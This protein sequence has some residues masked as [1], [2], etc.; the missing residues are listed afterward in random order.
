MLLSRANCSARAA[1]R[2][3]TAAASPPTCRRPGRNTA[4]A[5]FAVPMMPQRTCPGEVIVLS[6][7]RGIEGQ[8][9]PAALVVRD[10]HRVDD[11]L[12]PQPV[13][14]VPLVALDLAED[15][16]GE[17][18]G[19]VGVVEGPPRLTRAAAGRVVAVRDRHVP[20]LNIIRPGHLQRLADAELLDQPGAGCALA[21]VDAHLDVP[22]AV[23][24]EGLGHH[25]GAG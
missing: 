8:A 12:H 4:R 13:V 3:A 18:R 25:E 16:A 19:E 23:P 17:V 9:H 24:G 2:P 5:M 10:L 7:F 15:L 6:A 14:E 20:E 22:N 11:L 21:A 1:S